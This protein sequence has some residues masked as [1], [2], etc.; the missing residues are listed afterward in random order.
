LAYTYDLAGNM[1]TSTD[2]AGVT[3]T[4][5]VSPASEILSVTSALSNSTNP[6][7]LISSVQNSPNG[8]VSYNLGNGL[9]QSLFYDSLGRLADGWVCTGTPTWTCSGSNQAYGFAITRSGSQ[10][11]V[12]SDN[13]VGY[14]TTY[15]YD[16]FNRLSSSTNNA[17]Q[18]LYSYVYDR[19]GNRWQQNALQGG[20]NF[21]AAFNTATN[22]I[23]T[24]GY[25]YDAAG[26]MTNDNF[27]TYTY[28]AEGNVTAVDGGSTASYTYNALNQRVQTAV[29]S[30]LTEFVYNVN[31]QR[32]SI[33]NG[34]TNTQIQGQYYWGSK[35][36]AFYKNGQVH[37][38]H[39]DWLGTERVRTTYNGG[40]EGTYTSLPF[41]DAQ[42]PSGSD[43]DPYHYASL[44]YD[45]ETTTDHAQFRQ[46]N[47]R[48][49]RW[50]SADPY[51][52][53]YNFSNPQTLNRY[54][55]VG[56]SPLSAIDPSGLEVVCDVIA[57]P[58]GNDVT[59]WEHCDEDGGLGRGGNG[60]GNGGGRGGG[61]GGGS[62][63]PSNPCANSTLAAADTTGQQQIATA[64]G[65]IA[66]GQIGASA[67]P[68]ANPVLSFFGGMY[69]YYEAVHTG[70]PNDI[71][72]QP[73]PGYHNQT[74][75]DAGNISFGITCPYGGG[76][77]QFAAGLA[78]TLSGN[79]NFNGTLATGYDTPSDNAGIRVG[80]AMRVAGCHE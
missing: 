44:D 15:G 38:Q 27:H 53:S 21:T 31:G 8:P 54:A 51:Y 1:K 35:P 55:Y 3:S 29:G 69:G 50:M 9:S 39:Q 12:I 22:H 18:Q 74:G 79:P 10:I 16:E 45:S 64:Q 65:Y 48:Q 58:N 41:G 6:A 14:G 36:V 73:G 62:A 11:K 23:T 70:G 19:Y 61:G 71:K 13:I 25:A 37:F 7:N 56:N 76:F 40:V 26:N 68:Y 78:Q 57:V 63:A 34:S 43:L 4:Y 52:G 5:T 24:A 2:G 17:G 80:Q 59:N 32:V 46:Y 67:T 72:N 28:D 77:C 75:V 42:N 47:S 49:D 60:G 33:W 66:A 20:S 30:T